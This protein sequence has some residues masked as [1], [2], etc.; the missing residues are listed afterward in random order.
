MLFYFN[1]RLSQFLPVIDSDS[2]WVVEFYAPWCGHCQAFAP[3]FAKLAKVLKGVIKVGGV[4]M[5]DHASVGAP[6]NVKGFPT[7]KIFGADKQSPIDYNGEADSINELRNL[8]KSRIGGKTSSSKKSEKVLL[9]DSNF[10][11]K[12]TSSD[13]MWL[14]EFFAPWC[15]HCKNLAPHWAAAATE[16]RGKV[17]LAAIDATANT[18]MA[19][20]FGIQG[21]PTIKMFPSGSKKLEDAVDYDGGRTS[22]DI[23]QWALNKLAENVPPPEVV[24]ITDKEVFDKA[25]SKSQLCVISFFPHILDCQ[26]KC[27]NDYLSVLHDMG[28]KYKKH[29]WGWI[30][31]EAG[32]QPKLEEA[33]SVVNARKVKHSIF[34]GSFDRQ[35]ISEFLR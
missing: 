19:Q 35:G 10:E 4:N 22:S 11:E 26:S 6:Y 29:M 32:A 31:A 24:Q 17:K 27:R 7:I 15:G 12:I 20:K 25:C 21:F 33:M 23:V 2:V 30:W 3:E 18:A 9:D 8:V 1:V 34:K 16:L 14:V 5:V 13:D 28:E